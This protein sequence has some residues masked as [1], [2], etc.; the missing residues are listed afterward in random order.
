MTDQP[1]SGGDFPPES[2][3][4]W[5]PAPPPVPE[6]IAPLPPIVPPSM[7][8]E[9]L[10]PWLSM[11]TRPRATMRQILDTD[12]SMSR[13]YGAQA[14]PLV[15]VI[16]QNGTIRHRH[17]GY[18]PRGDEVIAREVEALLKEKVAP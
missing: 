5:A 1:P 9:P 17:V 4:P 11:W 2:A 8:A 16:D 6:T 3:P 12:S 18:S 13:A 15:V 7:R 14:I 10:N